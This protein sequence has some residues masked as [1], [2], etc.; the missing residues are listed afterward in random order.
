MATCLEQD[1][2]PVATSKGLG[3]RTAQREGLLRNSV[4]QG[5]A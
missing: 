3:G 5:G 2:S 4:G 1:P